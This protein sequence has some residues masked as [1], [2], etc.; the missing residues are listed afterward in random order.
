MDTKTYISSNPCIYIYI[1]NCKTVVE[2]F[3]RYK[4]YPMKCVVPTNSTVLKL[5]DMEEF[6]NEETMLLMLS[7]TW[8]MLEKQTSDTSQITKHFIISGK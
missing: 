2:Y 1:H 7:L 4:I 3:L 6:A 5:R 8:K